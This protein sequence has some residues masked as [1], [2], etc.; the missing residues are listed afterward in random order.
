MSRLASPALRLILAP[1]AVAAF[2]GFRLWHAG[3]LAAIGVGWC[4]FALCVFAIGAW[5]HIQLARTRSRLRSRRD[6]RP[7]RTQ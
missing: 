7:S 2:V 5:G 6:H 1:A 3:E 4:V